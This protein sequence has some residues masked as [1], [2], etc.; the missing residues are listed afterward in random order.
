MTNLLTG[1]FLPIRVENENLRCT[2]TEGRIPPDL[3]GT[4]FVKV[5]PNPVYDLQLNQANHWFDGNGHLHSITIHGDGHVTYS[6]KYVRNDMYYI[7]KAANAPIYPSLQTLFG[8]ETVNILTS[9]IKLSITSIL[10]RRFRFTKSNTSVIKD[11]DRL[12]VLEENGCPFAVNYNRLDT[13][14]PETFNGTWGFFRQGWDGFSAHPKRC[15]I[16]GQLHVIGYETMYSQLRYSIIDKK[17]HVKVARTKVPVACPTMIHDVA[18]TNKYMV[19]CVH[20]LRFDVT[21]LLYGKA[22]LYYDQTEWCEWVFIDKKA[23]ERTNIATVAHSFRSRAF[24]VTHFANAYEVTE[25]SVSVFACINQDADFHNPANSGLSYMTQFKFNLKTHQIEEQ[26]VGHLPVDFPQVPPT[27]TGHKSQFMVA[28]TQAHIHPDKWDTLKFDGLVRYE[29]ENHHIV[30]LPFPQSVY[31]GDTCMTETHIVTFVHD[32]C[33]DKS[34][35]FIINLHTMIIECKIC[36]PTR[37]P[38]GFHMCQVK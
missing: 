13:I 8:N 2:V 5:G 14:G 27:K 11:G 19:V 12:L 1:N 29:P 23:T 10:W 9:Y 7:E 33:T 6:N 31:G 4:Q 3:L 21:R 36:I 22:L 35:V 15:P 37:V 18:M 17:G 32:E 25:D 24:V 16:T 28:S 34:Y 38:Y 30:H 26:V 20:P